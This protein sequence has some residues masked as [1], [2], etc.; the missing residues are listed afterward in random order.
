MGNSQSQQQLDETKSQL[1]AE[2]KRSAQLADEKAQLSASLA[3]EQQKLAEQQRAHDEALESS[4]QEVQQKQEALAYAMKR[5]EI[6]EGRMHGQG[7]FSQHAVVVTI[8]W[9]SVFQSRLGR[10]VVVVGLMAAGRVL[11]LA[12]HTEAKKIA[13]RL[14]EQLLEVE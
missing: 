4:R 13:Q 11:V 3:R 12:A 8:M 14:G 9:F 10:V 2:K 1:A 7:W 6:A 5:Q